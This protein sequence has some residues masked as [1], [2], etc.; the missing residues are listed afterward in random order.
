MIYNYSCSDTRFWSCRP[1]LQSTDYFYKSKST[2]LKRSSLH[3]TKT[4]SCTVVLDSTLCGLFSLYER[5]DSQRLFFK[6][7]AN[8]RSLWKQG[9]PL[10]RINVDRESYLSTQISLGR[11]QHRAVCAKDASMSVFRFQTGIWCHCAVFV[12]LLG[13]KTQ[14][15]EVSYIHPAQ[16]L[17]AFASSRLCGN[18]H[19]SLPHLAEGTRSQIMVYTLGS[20]S[21][22]N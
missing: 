8:E 2:A 15:S 17:C 9:H 13:D 21:A 1:P 6:C 4:F 19:H 14:A 16:G 3:Q 5:L 10:P 12:F 22:S 7:T 18:Q 20:N 11:P